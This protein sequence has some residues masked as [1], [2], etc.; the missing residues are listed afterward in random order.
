MLYSENPFRKIPFGESLSEN[1][2]WENLYS[3]KGT[4]PFIQD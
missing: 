3:E 2:D 1:P 4:Q